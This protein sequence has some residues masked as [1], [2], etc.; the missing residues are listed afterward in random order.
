[1]ATGATSNHSRQSTTS[2]QGTP[3][4]VVLSLDPP[5]INP[6]HAK[7]AHRE[8]RPQPADRRPTRVR[9]QWTARL[10]TPSDAELLHL[11]QGTVVLHIQ[12]AAI[13]AAG[14]VIKV[15][16]TLCPADWTVLHHSS[17]IAPRP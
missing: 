14:H 1:M 5:T 3:T 6:Q 9:T 7:P 10:A 13:D 2:P 8:S 16:T 11:P 17:P 12:R 4:P 15:T